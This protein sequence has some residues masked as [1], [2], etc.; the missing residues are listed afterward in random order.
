M[1]PGISA[2]LSRRALNADLEATLT[3]YQHRCRLADQMIAEL[4]ANVESDTLIR[5][6]SA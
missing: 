6:V 5:V 1:K 4:P 3:Q 2:T